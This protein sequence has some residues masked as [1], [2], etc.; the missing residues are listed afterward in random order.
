M[1]ATLSLIA[2]PGEGGGAS[3]R[4][5]AG[6]GEGESLDCADSGCRPDN[7][8]FRSRRHFCRTEGKDWYTV[9]VILRIIQA[10]TAV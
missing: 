6:T 10:I 2:L 1:L 9:C 7:M 5:T 8:A 4:A 3:S